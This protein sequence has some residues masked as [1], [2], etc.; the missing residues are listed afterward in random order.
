MTSNR[1]GFD[2][3][4]IGAGA[5]GCV[6]ANRLSADPKRRVALIEAGSSDRHFP[7]SLKTT[8][9]IGNIFLLPQAATN[10]QHEFTGGAGVKQRQIPC[11]R[12]R[13]LGGSTSVNG[14][15][16][17]R[18][19]RLDYDEW[20]ALGNTGWAW[21]EVLP[22]FKCHE[23]F[24]RGA[25]AW[26]GHGGELSV[27]RPAMSNP[28][29]HA[30]VQAAAEAGFAKNDD[31]NSDAQDG[32]GI[33]DLNQRN[34]VRWSSSRAF[35]HPVLGRPNLTLFVDALVQRIRLQGTRAVGVT[36]RQHGQL[37]DLHAGTEII[38]CG[39]S[40]N[41]PQLLMLSGIGPGA[42]A[43]HGIPV[44]HELAGVGQNLQD[45]PT[46][47]LAM[48]N[49]SAESYALSWRT[50]PRV[51]MAPLRYAFGRRGMLVHVVDGIA[52][53]DLD[54]LAL[55]DFG[56]GGSDFH[57]PGLPRNSTPWRWRR[58]RPEDSLIAAPESGVAALRGHHV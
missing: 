8:L 21:D 56:D 44:L 47:S 37:I 9:P 14:T 52:D 31:F 7:L 57:G 34:G 24:D 25:N 51:A 3:L 49:P 17:I 58:V 28:L 45:H 1:T 12:G 50:A 10:W 5:A 19:H 42:I 41:S 29:A 55:E 54:P 38:V 22:F 46:V 33:F 35:L 23:D 16:Y 11:P 26:H 53:E 40:V 39:G 18:G 43:Q 32:F 48:T 15:V 27:Q 36:L 4:I 2:T 6:I 30:F 13:L 20:A